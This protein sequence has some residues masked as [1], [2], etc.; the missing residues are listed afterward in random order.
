MN[1]TAS[2]S[3]QDYLTEDV[4]NVP[5]GVLLKMVKSQI[6]FPLALIAV[7]AIK[8]VSKFKGRT[9]AINAVC[10]NAE[11]VTLE[12][13]PAQARIAFEGLAN[14]LKGFRWVSFQRRPCLGLRQQYEAV[15]LHEDGFMIALCE[16]QHQM[17]VVT[18]VK[19]ED[20]VKSTEAV[21]TEFLSFEGDRSTIITTYMPRE[22]MAALSLY[23]G[24]LGEVEAV[25]NDQR[26]EVA[27]EKHVERIKGVATNTM[28]EE[29]ACQQ[30]K[31]HSDKVVNHFMKLGLIRTLLPQEVPALLKYREKHS[32]DF[33]PYTYR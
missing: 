6:F 12:E 29:G 5:F 4:T 7:I 13:M 22:H 2:I 18:A 21:T 25:V 1:E 19:G 8:V 15:A 33:E 30:A 3:H 24:G 23:D 16:W 14:Q 9:D 26:M 27:I 17:V 32:D 11:P 10:K 31:K 20:P 28:N